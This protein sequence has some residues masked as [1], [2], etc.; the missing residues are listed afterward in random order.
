MDERSRRTP[1]LL[2]LLPAV[3]VLLMAAQSATAATLYAAPTSHGSGNCSAEANACTAEAAI[4]AA[5][6]SDTVVLLGD[7]GT[8]GTTVKPLTETIKASVPDTPAAIEGAPGQPRPVI[9]TT[10][11]EGVELLNA[12]GEGRSTSLS[13]VEIDDTGTDTVALL[14]SGDVDHVIARAADGGAGC[15]P[16]TDEAGT[17]LVRDSLCIGEGFESDGMRLIIAGSSSTQVGRAT[18]RNDTFY[19][20]GKFSVGMDISSHFFTVDLTAVN[21]ITHGEVEDLSTFSNEGAVNITLSHCNYTRLSEGSGT[22]ITESPVGSDVKTNPQF[23]DAAGDDLEEAPGSPTIDTG[24]NEAA[25]GE[26]DLA[27][28]PRTIGP[29][30]DIGAYEAVDGPTVT[31]T[32]I[33]ALTETS[34]LLN[35]D[36]D[37]DGAPT[38]VQAFLGTSTSTETAT[39]TQ[40]PGAGTSAVAVAFPVGSLTPGTVYHYHFL[41]VNSVGSNASADETFTTPGTTPVPPAPGK[42]TLLS[43]TATLHGSSAPI[44]LSCSSPSLGCRGVLAITLRIRGRVLTRLH[45]HLHTH[46]VTVTVI[47]AKAAFT[48]AAGQTATVLLP[49][50]KEARTR[51]TRARHRRLAVALAARRSDGG[52]A[53]TASL[54]LIAPAKRSKRSHKH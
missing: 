30:T 48:L 3:A 32:P 23:V 21:V 9:D 17:Q 2:A 37:P 24:V 22:T 19:A 31:P 40:S 38:T 6:S 28:R 8:Y 26:T 25:N 42:V 16:T 51:L 53:A 46:Y 13:D 29:L 54:E 7:E 33:T 14:T 18:L 10:A 27:G 43:S 47:L 1:R 45:G 52:A 36:V 20:S 44:K 41:A 5:T 49:L 34:A 39:A 15:E 35:A 12:S 11:A 50:T 4:T